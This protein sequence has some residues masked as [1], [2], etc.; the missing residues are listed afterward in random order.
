MLGSAGFGLFLLLAFLLFFLG[1]INLLG[2]F[3]SGFPADPAQVALLYIV[4]AIIGPIAEEIFFRGLLFTY[5]RRWGMIPALILSTAAFVLLHP[6]QGM[7]VTQIIGGL[8]FGIS[9]ELEKN[10]MVPIVIHVAGNT[11]IFTLPA[12]F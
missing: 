3:N 2:F 6:V 10:L 1:G 11:A 4:G 9:F 5:L 8:L 7:A 12:I